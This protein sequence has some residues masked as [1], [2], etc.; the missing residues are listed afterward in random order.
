[1]HTNTFTHR[2]SNTQT[3]LHT[4]P[5]THK[6]FDTETLWHTEAATRG[7]HLHTDPLTHK[8]LHSYTN[9]LL[10][11]TSVTSQFFLSFWRSTL[12]SCERVAPGQ[13]GTSK[14]AN[15]PQFLT[16]DHHFVRRG[17]LQDKSGTRKIAIFPQFLTIDPHFVRKGCSGTSPAQEKS[18]FYLSFWRSTLISCERVA[19]GQVNSQFYPV[20]ADRP[21]FRAKGLLQDKSGTRKIA[22]FPQFLTID[23]HFVRKGCSGTSPA[24]EKSQFFLSFWRSTLISCERVVP[25]QEKPQFYLSFCQSTLISC[26]RVAPGQVNSQFYL[27]FCRSTLISCERVAPAQE[28]SQF[29]RSF[30]RST[31]ISC[32]RVVVSWLAAGTTLG[33][34]RER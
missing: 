32:E 15:F 21:S 1:M 25:G 31:L 7:P 14:I 23:P 3:L 5:F 24:Q 2:P 18:Q 20:F 17:L 34:K 30:C 27:S 13:V 8:R 19:P 10:H 22:I 29:Y 33:L 26:E 4:N 6:P 12:I 28:K 16:I 11:P 9:T